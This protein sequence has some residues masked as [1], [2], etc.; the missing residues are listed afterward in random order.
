MS[1]SQ[2]FQANSQGDTAACQESRNL[3]MDALAEASAL[4]AQNRACLNETAIDQV[5]SL[6]QKADSLDC[7]NVIQQSNLKVVPSVAGFD[8]NRATST[9]NA[10][11][12]T[13]I[14]F[15]EYLKPKRPEDVGKVIN[16]TP[17]P[18]Q[19]V[20]PDTVIRVSTF[21]N[22]WKDPKEADRELSEA[23]A[24]GGAWDMEADQA[25]VSATTHSRDVSNFPI[26]TS[27][28][29][30]GESQVERAKEVAQE[31]SAKG[32][33]AESFITPETL[34]GLMGVAAGIA[35]STKSGS[36]QTGGSTASTPMPIQEI[37]PDILPGVIPSARTTG[38]GSTAP[39]GNTVPTSGDGGG[40]CTVHY[41]GS[42]GDTYYV[43]DAGGRPKGFEIRRVWDPPRG[44]VDRMQCGTHRGA[45]RKC[46][47]DSVKYMGAT[48]SVHGPFNNL[49][50]AQNFTRE[51]CR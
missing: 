6:L 7:G 42:E 22:E 1:G 17:P 33:Q 18:G 49:A 31:A 21:N 16:T 23:G 26:D 46:I 5:N 15:F 27:A 3:A 36:S 40:N 20:P 24:D 41:S 11:G 35:S 45:M 19:M 14:F 37:G 43:I 32:P 13:N 28:V 2:A 29:P 10:A 44:D 9:L 25:R 12:F 48:V 51:R 39:A 34:G 50:Q 30:S 4:A 38:R 8:K 47:N